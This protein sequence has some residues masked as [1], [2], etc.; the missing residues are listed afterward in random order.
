MVIGG[1][2]S[3]PSPLQTLHSPPLGKHL[4]S[5]APSS[6]QETSLSNMFLFLCPYFKE[7]L[8]LQAIPALVCWVLASLMA[9][10]LYDERGE[11]TLAAGG[12]VWRRS[13]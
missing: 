6:F 13:G 4:S 5:S 8:S 11:E 10:L 12:V 2:N 7:L 9:A 3:Q 1:L